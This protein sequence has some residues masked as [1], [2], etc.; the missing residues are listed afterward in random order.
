MTLPSA[1]DAVTL[2]T[3]TAGGTTLP[4][5]DDAVTLSTLPQPTQQLP[6]IT[7]TD[8]DVSAIGRAWPAWIARAQRALETKNS[9]CNSTGWRPPEP[10]YLCSAPLLRSAYQLISKAGS[11]YVRTRL[12]EQYGAPSYIQCPPGRHAANHYNMT[13]GRWHWFTFVRD[14]VER[15]LSAVTEVSIQKPFHPWVQKIN[16]SWVLNRSA[17]RRGHAPNRWVPPDQPPGVYQKHKQ[18]DMHYY[19][20]KDARE[21]L[22]MI[23]FLVTQARW[24]DIHFRS[25]W[26]TVLEAAHQVPHLVARGFVGDVCNVSSMFALLVEREDRNRRQQREAHAHAVHAAEPAFKVDANQHRYREPTARAEARNHPSPS[27]AQRQRIQAHYALDYECLS[28]PKDR[29][30]AC[31][32]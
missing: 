31:H 20:P 6:D 7:V 4:S 24:G 23:E 19:Y 2:P 32:L 9:K 16:S 15:F 10:F 8:A 18:Y 12:Y 30:L 1:G 21:R 3:P 25:Q 11:S 29:S 17:P 28:L 22:S 26:A 13:T 14:P 5:A 27:R